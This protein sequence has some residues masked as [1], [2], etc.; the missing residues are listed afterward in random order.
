M[1]VGFKH[2]NLQQVSYALYPVLLFLQHYGLRKANSLDLKQIYH[3]SKTCMLL[4]DLD[5]DYYY[6]NPLF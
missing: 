3:V 1:Y 6:G 2:I 4:C 5:L